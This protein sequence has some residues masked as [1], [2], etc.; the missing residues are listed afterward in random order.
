M[1]ELIKQIIEG[2]KLKEP[3]DMEEYFTLELEN[4]IAIL[5]DLHKNLS[6]CIWT[7]EITD[8][9]VNRLDQLR[10]LY[11]IEL[12]HMIQKARGECE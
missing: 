6:D 12:I 11:N 8:Y 2:L 9:E 1:K 4:E 5:M 7:N 10:R 3:E